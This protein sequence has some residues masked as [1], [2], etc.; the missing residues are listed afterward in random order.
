MSQQ[1][2]KIKIFGERNSGTNYIKKLLTENIKSHVYIEGGNYKSKSGWKHG[3]PDSSKI[4]K[5]TL[6]IFIVREL[7]T[8]LNSMYFR[9]YHIKRQNNF[10]RF[11]TTKNKS[12]DKRQNH[13]VNLYKY[14]RENLF[15]IRYKKF[16]KYLSLF[17]THNCILLNLNFVQQY[18]ENL[19]E[20][21]DYF[22]IETHKKFTLILKHTKI[23]INVQNDQTHQK[24]EIP[25]KIYNKYANHKIE[26]Y[27]GKLSYR[28][29]KI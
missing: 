19:I 11:I 17:K 25:S 4:D 12:N 14:E 1:I 24:Y 21:L 28:I 20:L 15:K 9:P 26:T 2:T 6:V 7:S 3:L 29:N 10:I 22:N 5:Q 8:W 23:G 13:P 16:K 27:I 18:P